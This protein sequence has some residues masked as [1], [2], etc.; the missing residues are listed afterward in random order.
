MI[1][2]RETERFKEWIKGLADRAA[3]QRINARL[4]GIARHG[5]FGECRPIGA[6]LSELIF[7]F[8]PGYRVYFGQ[9][10]EK[11]VIILAGG[12]KSTQSA[13]IEKAHE[14]WAAWLEQDEELKD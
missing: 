5:R 7:T 13:D 14:E 6:G 11:L 8:G 12:D 1:D 9:R 10:G 2:I 4:K 3:V